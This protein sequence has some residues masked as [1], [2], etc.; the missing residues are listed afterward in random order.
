MFINALM[1]IL[2]TVQLFL[3]IDYSIE[4]VINTRAK[5][6]TLALGIFVFIWVLS[7][8]L[9]GIAEDFVWAAIFRAFGVLGING[10]IVTEL[11]F[12]TSQCHPA[13][14]A[15]F[16]VHSV[17][18]LYSLFDTVFFGSPEVNSFIRVSERTAYLANDTW[19]RTFH[20]VYITVMAL[21]LLIVWNIWRRGTNYKREK[22][23]LNMIFL[24]NIAILIGC[25]PDTFFPLFGIPSW[26]S[27][28]I[29][30]FITYCIIRHVGRQHSAFEISEKN[31]RDFTFD[32]AN[33]G[34]L[35]FFPD[36]HLGEANIYARRLLNIDKVEKSLRLSE[37]FTL[38]TF[39]EKTI[40][41]DALKGNDKRFKTTTRKGRISVLVNLHMETDE[42][43]YPYCVFATVV[44]ETHEDEMIGELSELN[45]ART[46]FLSGMSHEIRTPVN[47]IMGMDEMIL[48]TS[49][50][51][52]IRGYA[53]SIKSSCNLLIS[54]INDVLDFSKIESG[55]ISLSK[56][57]YSLKSLM[58]DIIRMLE[59]STNRKNLHM[60]VS[61][62]ENLPTRLYGDEMRI[63]QIVANLVSNAVKYTDHGTVGIKIHDGGRKKNQVRL[64]IEV[65]DTGKGIKKEDQRNLF[66]AF[67]RVDERKNRHIV[68]TGLGLS[69][70]SHFVHLMN[71]TI[72]VD[73]EYGKWSVFSVVIP[74]EIASDESIGNFEVE[75]AVP[76]GENQAHEII[77]AKGARVL[78]VD[79]NEMNLN[80]AALLLEETLMSVD[81]SMMGETA[82]EMMRSNEYDLIFLDHMMPVM[83]GMQVLRA[84]KD[85]GLQKNVPVVVLTA[86]AIAGAKEMYLDKGF[87]DYLSKPII[88]AELNEILKKWLPKELIGKAEVAK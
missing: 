20:N 45:E 39:E 47:T 22:N 88:C 86:N 23:Y 6:Y 31:L 67:R 4:G 1:I 65:S 54:I 29:G 85:E 8:G 62:D 25:I 12:L 14:P 11:L 24:S 80:V 76:D 2:S 41:E 81:T 40:F 72:G 27:S 61:I 10:F 64:C 73:S 38:T 84:M 36:Q 83:D 3:V 21:G 26:P 69:I 75:C 70:A 28:A 78:I 53:A 52:R 17:F 35:A 60:E 77:K 5:K 46:A 66:E 68:G 51:P 9:M 63:R 59:E 43:G 57:E 74:Q 49:I 30:G 32:Y 42:N 58:N 50:E 16:I 44:D 71:G 7:Y 18:T 48:R 87:D 33:V 79:D 56:E 13:K 15:K 82:L 19:K 34:V 55:E 37:L